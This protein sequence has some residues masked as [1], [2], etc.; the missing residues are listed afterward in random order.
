MIQY[1]QLIHIIKLLRFFIQISNQPIDRYN[2]YNFVTLRQV[3][4]PGGSPPA[5]AFLDWRNSICCPCISN[6]LELVLFNPIPKHFSAR[7]YGVLLN[8]ISERP[9][10]LW[11]Y[12]LL[13]QLKLILNTNKIQ[14]KPVSKSHI[15]KIGGLFFQILNGV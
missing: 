15:S 8:V 9:N 10:C 13:W 6:G 11:V 7:Y 12:W 3:P 2:S 5:V 1:H 14:E 4:L